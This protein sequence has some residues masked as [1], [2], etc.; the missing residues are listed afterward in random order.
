MCNVIWWLI[1]LIGV[2]CKLTF[3][4]TTESGCETCENTV[5]SA[6][7]REEE[8]PSI[9]ANQFTLLF[10]SYFSYV[11]KI[12]TFQKIHCSLTAKLAALRLLIS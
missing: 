1:D 9:F 4:I 8:N 2:L 5:K 3:S 10:E 6:P 7:L 12:F 11:T